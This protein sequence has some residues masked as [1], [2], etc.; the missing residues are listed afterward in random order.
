MK[1]LAKNKRANFDYEI[2]DKLVAGIALLGAEVKSLRAGHA[3]LAGSYVSIQDGQAYLLNAHISPYQPA[4][5]KDYDPLRTRKLLLHKSEIMRLLGQKKT[6]LVAVPI[7]IVL[8]Q[9]LIKVEIGVGKGKKK[10]DKRATI[11][12][13]ET[14]REIAKKLKV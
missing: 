1:I 8:D 10:Y 9:N 14:E 7:A 6:G 11:K 4:G 5:L 2:K 12:K 3:S 13:R